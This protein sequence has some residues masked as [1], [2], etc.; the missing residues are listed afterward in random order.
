VY[1][2]RDMVIDVKTDSQADFAEFSAEVDRRYP[3]QY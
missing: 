1:I 3:L 2:P